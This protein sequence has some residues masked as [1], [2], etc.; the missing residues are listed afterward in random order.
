VLP[1]R[2]GWVDN[3]KAA[4]D[5]GGVD[6]ITAVLEK[7]G[8][9]AEIFG[10]SVNAL[11]SIAS[12]P[13]FCARMVE[14][15][16]IAATLRA[17]SEYWKTVVRDRTSASESA[18]TERLLSMMQSVLKVGPEQFVETGCLETLLV[19]ISTPPPLPPSGRATGKEVPAQ[20]PTVMLLA[21][22]L[23]ERISRSKVGQDVLM[24]DAS[25]QKIVKVCTVF[26]KAP[27]KS[28]SASTQKL[29]EST[30]NNM[31]LEFGF[32]LLDRVSRTE[33]G[34]ASLRRCEGPAV[35]PLAL[36]LRSPALARFMPHTS[37]RVFYRR[38][39]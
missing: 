16:A 28:T 39:Q 32:R 15:G 23:L 3:S 8:S 26:F 29:E 4:F 13:R 24:A 27:V 10:Y 19:I 22:Q 2:V 31:H 36:R 6:A 21:M 14:S 37:C 7:H 1:P 11:T 9:D 34:L 20:S 5:A 25:V 30:S 38:M 17:F 18:P 33:R 35:A 12:F